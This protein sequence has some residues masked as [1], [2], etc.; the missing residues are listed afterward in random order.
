[1][2]SNTLNLAKPS[3]GAREFFLFG[4][5]YFFLSLI[6]LRDKLLLTPAWFDG[7][8]ENNHNLL[9]QFSYSNNEQSRILQ[10]LIPELFHRL[11]SLRIEDAYILQRWLFVMLAFLGFHFYMRKWFS[12]SASFAGVLFLAA[13]FPLT[14]QDDLQESAPLL[15]LTFL[16]GLWAIR[17][18]NIPALTIISIIGGLN[19]ETMLALP[20]VYLSYHYQGSK[21]GDLVTLFRKTALISLPLVLSVGTVR[22]INRD[23]PALVEL[24]QLPDNIN[25]VWRQLSAFDLLHLYDASFLYVFFIFGVLWIYAF[26][27]YRELPLFL[28]RASLIVPLFVLAHFVAGYITEVRLM[29]P[30]SGIIVPMALG[31]LFPSERRWEILKGAEAKVENNVP[32]PH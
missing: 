14:N 18:D 22:F 10:F 26:I 31:F 6:V 5:V 29:L 13:V 16:G 11:F 30:L 12:P 1:M 19:N 21:I 2:R 3:G 20:L 7:T 17:D 9:V 23:R 27:G 4:S 32:L 24:W 15:L 28:R 8:L 25:G